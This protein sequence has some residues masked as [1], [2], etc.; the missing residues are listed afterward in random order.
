[1]IFVINLL[2]MHLF[3]FSF[4]SKTQKIKCLCSA[5]V[6]ECNLEG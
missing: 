1:M 6:D 5:G 4:N 2:E 3:L